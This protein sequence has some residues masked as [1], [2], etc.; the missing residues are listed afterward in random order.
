M[1]FGDFLR[2]VTHAIILTPPR[3]AISAILELSS[4]GGVMKACCRY[5]T[6]SYGLFMRGPLRGRQTV[7]HAM[8]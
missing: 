6:M 7:A 2:P 8:V 4:A 5:M 3:K 1:Y